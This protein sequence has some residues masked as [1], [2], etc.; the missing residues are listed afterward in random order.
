MDTNSKELTYTGRFGQ[1]I[2]CLGKQFRM[3]VTQSDWKFLPM[4]AVIA[5]MVSMAVGKG[6]FVSMEG[7]F[8]GMF[9]LTCVCI[10][11][12]FFNS[13]QTICRE[14]A[15]IKRE[16]R[17]GLHIT[18]YVVSHLVYQF[19][20][21][22]METGITIAVLGATGVKYPQTGVAFGF[23]PDLFLTLLFITYASDILALMIS[24][25][26]KTPMA[27]MTVMPFMLIVQ[28]VFAGFIT[29]SD[30]FADVV[31]MMI[32]SWGVRSLCCVADFNSLPAV[33][34]WNKM[35][36]ASG[37]IGLIGD[38]TLKNVLSVI[39][40]AGFRDVILKKLGEASFRADFVATPENL[41]MCWGHLILFTIVYAIVTVIFLEFIDK[42]KR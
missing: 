23:I 16:H 39:E 8:Q 27:A 36:S 30:A 11:N 17:A 2:I 21:C 31:K 28:L 6:L 12:G 3:F 15:I 19:F 29:L 13:I 24:A 40:Q 41:F 34:I 22:M 42:D 32:S 33:V 10:W 9:A 38:Y 14:R 5:A 35:V 18:S 20:M 26:V 1:F 37:N 7:T 4:S 25:M